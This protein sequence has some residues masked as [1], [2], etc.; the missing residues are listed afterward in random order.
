M[1]NLLRRLSRNLVNCAGTRSF[2]GLKAPH[3][4]NESALFA[5]LQCR[6][7]IIYSRPD[8]CRVPD[9][10]R[11]LQKTSDVVLNKIGELFGIELGESCA[12]SGT[13]AQHRRQRQARLATFPADQT[14]T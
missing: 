8:L 5:Q 7:R 11:V 2:L 12:N 10:G 14:L 3:E 6:A 9:N 1:V 13:F 4:F